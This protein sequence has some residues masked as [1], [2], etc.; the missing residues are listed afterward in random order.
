MK[1][2]MKMKT[3]TAVLALLLLA[4]GCGGNDLGIPPDGSGEIEPHRVVK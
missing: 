1:T 2:K 4:A 3:W